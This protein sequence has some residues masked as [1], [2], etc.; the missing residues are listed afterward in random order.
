MT[1]MAINKIKQCEPCSIF[2]SAPPFGG[3]KLG[4]GQISVKMGLKVDPGGKK[5]N[6]KRVLKYPQKSTHRQL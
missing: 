3:V 2:F 5:Q 6:G 1:Q 4:I